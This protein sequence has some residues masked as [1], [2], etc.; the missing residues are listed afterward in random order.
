MWATARYNIYTLHN[1]KGPSRKMDHLHQL[2]SNQA[3]QESTST[4]PSGV[5]FLCSSCQETSRH[6][7][8]VLRAIPAMSLPVTPGGTLATILQ[9]CSATSSTEL[10]LEWIPDFPA[11]LEKGCGSTRRLQA[12]SGHGSVPPASWRRG[13]QKMSYRSQLAPQQKSW[14]VHMYKIQSVLYNA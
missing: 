12:C 14:L 9:A 4:C 1:R 6:F 5:S 7:F 8:C 3:S 2:N 11:A 10:H 13:F